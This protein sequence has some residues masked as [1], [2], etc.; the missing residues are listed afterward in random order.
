MVLA[1]DRSDHGQVLQGTKADCD[2][3]YC[4]II[5]HLQVLF[6]S[7]RCNSLET[8]SLP[9]PSSRRDGLLGRAYVIPHQ[10]HNT[11][12]SCKS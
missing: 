10:T 9:F 6:W 5:I 8:C 11:L 3:K 1:I 12:L 4:D 2:I 7:L